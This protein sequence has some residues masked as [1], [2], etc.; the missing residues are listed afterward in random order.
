MKALRNWILKNFLPT[1]KSNLDLLKMKIQGLKVQL[2]LPS[3][4]GEANNRTEIVSNLSDQ[5]DNRSKSWMN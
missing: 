5:K 1:T 2:P 3:W 4:D